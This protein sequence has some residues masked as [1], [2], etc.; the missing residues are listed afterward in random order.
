MLVLIL[1]IQLV[2][3][4]CM[5]NSLRSSFE[6]NAEVSSALLAQQIKKALA[7]KV[8]GQLDELLYNARASE[9]DR[10]YLVVLDADGKVLSA[11]GDA[12]YISDLE[13]FISLYGEQHAG[14]AQSYEGQVLHVV[15]PLD[16][17]KAGSLHVGLSWASVDAT[18]RNVFMNMTVVTLIG[19]AF[20][21][22]VAWVYFCRM[23]RPVVDIIET[24]RAFGGGQLSVRAKERPGAQDEAALLASVF[25]QM[26]DQTERQVSDLIRIQNDLADEKA[27][28][29]SIVDSMTQS[30][31]LVSNEGRIAYCNRSAK[32]F[33]QRACNC[34]EK[35]Y[36]VHRVNWPEA[37]QAFEEVAGG[38]ASFRRMQ[39]HVD[40]HDLELMVVP[41]MDSNGAPL[42]IVEIVTDTT[43]SLSSWRSLAHAE[44]LNV[45]GQLAAG[46]AHEINSPLDGAIEASRI[47]ERN[48]QTPD[49]AKRFCQAQRSALERIALIVRRLLTFSR[50]PSHTSWT[51]VRVSR[52]LEEAQA[53]LRHRLARLSL[54]LPPASGVAFHVRGDELGLVQVLV[55]LLNN[56]IDVTPERG[57][58][59][60][61]VETKAPGRVAISI[62]DQGP[63]VSDEVARKLF[64]PF[65]TTK[66]IG[67]GTGLGLSVSRNIVQ[68]HGGEIEFENLTPPLGARFTVIL[69]VEPVAPSGEAP[70]PAKPTELECAVTR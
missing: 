28:V 42:G 52:L 60:V 3:F 31:T 68:E 11:E 5:R 36:A 65:F 23:T 38:K 20:L 9:H 34:A 2:A 61:K 54:D 69:P 35:T 18:T 29:Q 67:K 57:E 47:I 24:V 12:F 33:C 44:K 55:N 62:V 8:P 13:Q 25:N 64:T 46:V 51:V 48:L 59:K 7:T 43:E 19:L 70:G 58:V 1:S 39:R 10:L 50:A 49:K 14:H 17:G 27:R 26:A 53:L 21:G 4:F 56:A 22:L 40:G 32:R 6:R 37:V 41:A 45:V 16:G 30:V 63:G 66:E 15:H